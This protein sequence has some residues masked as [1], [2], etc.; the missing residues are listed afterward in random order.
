MW[1]E[2]YI[3]N[4]D[5]DHVASCRQNDQKFSGQWCPELN[6]LINGMVESNVNLIPHFRYQVEKLVTNYW[7]LFKGPK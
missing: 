2:E 5:D 6:R 7:R 3:I 4:S 1:L